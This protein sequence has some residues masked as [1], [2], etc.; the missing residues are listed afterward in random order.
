MKALKEGINYVINLNI[1]K[2]LNSKLIEIRATG[3]KTLDVAK[4]KSITVYEGGSS[5]EPHIAIFWEVLESFT[6]EEKS[7]YLKFVWGRARLPASTQ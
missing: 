6:D 2:F 3:S 4:L 5:S 1:L 7:L